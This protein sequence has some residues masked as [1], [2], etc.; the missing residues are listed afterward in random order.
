MGYDEQ[1]LMIWDEEATQAFFT[2]ATMAVRLC[3]F[4]KPLWVLKF[5]SRPQQRLGVITAFV[6]LFLIL[7]SVATTARPIESL[8]GAAG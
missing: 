6:V 3:I 8:A 1:T 5:V 7:F 4:I 2:R